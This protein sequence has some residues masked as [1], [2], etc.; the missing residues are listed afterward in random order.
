M[1]KLNQC[2]AW[3]PGAKTELWY[4]TPALCGK[5][6]FLVSALCSALEKPVTR[7]PHFQT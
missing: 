5:G 6:R 1:G 3:E 2:P 4:V 7:Q